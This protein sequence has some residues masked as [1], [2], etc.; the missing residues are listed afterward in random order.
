[1][2]AGSHRLS[3][4]QALLKRGADA[5]ALDDAGNTVL[6]H[7]FTRFTFCF[8]CVERVLEIPSILELLIL[9]G[10]DHRHVNC[11]GQLPH[12]RLSPKIEATFPVSIYLAL[13]SCVWQEA[14]RRSGIDPAGY[15][16]IE[17]FFKLQR[18]TDEMSHCCLFH[19]RSFSLKQDRVQL[20]RLEFEDQ[21]IAVLECSTFI[22]KAMAPF[23]RRTLRRLNNFRVTKVMEF[24]SELKT[25]KMD[26]DRAGSTVVRFSWDE[27]HPQSKMELHESN[28]QQT[29]PQDCDGVTSDG[30]SAKAESSEV[31]ERCQ[32]RIKK[33]GERWEKAYG[34]H[35]EKDH[36][37]HLDDWEFCEFWEG[38]CDLVVEEIDL[39]TESE[40]HTDMG[41]ESEQEI[42]SDPKGE[43]AY[44]SA[45]E[46]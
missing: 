14:L 18:C 32:R 39:D 42:D 16:S 24:L 27:P 44:F 40:K 34:E 37:D 19:R 4:H 15:V 17:S 10:A 21:I 6:H 45:E 36:G 35:W 20:E 41:A 11:R 13:A 5:R 2:L 25:K 38:L 12:Q 30:T 1:M 28:K 22:Q 31:C 9:T 26:L 8:S 29:I 3:V 23:L 7:Y 33:R 46:A 43:E